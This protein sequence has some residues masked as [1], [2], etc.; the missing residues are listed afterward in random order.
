MKAILNYGTFVKEM[1]VHEPLRV[2]AVP[3]P[4][5]ITTVE[6]QSDPSTIKYNVLL[7]E[8]ISSP[9]IGEPLVYRFSGE[10]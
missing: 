5:V 9:R 1:E 8:L 4:I 7:F 3:K 2:I 10:G 6:N